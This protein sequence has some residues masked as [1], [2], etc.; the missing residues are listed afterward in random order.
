MRVCD[1]CPNSLASLIPCSPFFHKS[2]LVSSL[3]LNH[4]HH[5]RRVPNTLRCARRQ[6]S[7]SSI[8]NHHQDQSGSIGNGRCCGRMRKVNLAETSTEPSRASVRSSSDYSW[9]QDSVSTRSE[10]LTF[11]RSSRRIDPPLFHQY[12]IP[13]G[14]LV[15]A[16]V[17]IRDRMDAVYV[18][19]PSS[20]SRERADLL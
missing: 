17:L 10:S 19:I 6:T 12:F 4:F 7:S 11:P 15:D 5:S 16:G 8:Y 20:S 18:E 3:L 14:K 2:R 13:L 1:K 9:D